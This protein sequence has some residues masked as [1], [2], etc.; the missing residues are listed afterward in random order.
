[1][2]YVNLFPVTLWS[3]KNLFQDLQGCEDQK[4][5]QVDLNDHIHVVLSKD[6][7]S[8]A[9]DD[10]E[11]GWDKHSQQ[12]ADNR[13]SKGDFNNNGFQVVGRIH[14]MDSRFAHTNLAQGVTA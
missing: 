8:E 13:S 3:T 5:G 10:E 1:M 12:V 7:C 9:D 11:Q 14:D 2:D 4:N 6:P